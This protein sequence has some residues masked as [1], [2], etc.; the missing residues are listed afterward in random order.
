VQRIPA[1][2]HL[3]RHAHSASYVTLVLEGFYEQVGYAGRW[4]AQAGDVLIQ[5][6]LDC[7]ADTMHSRGLV[8][9]R[10]PWRHEAGPGGVWRG[11]D[12]DEIRRAGAVDP[13]AGRALVAAR[14]AGRPP[15]AAVEEHWVDPLAARL[16]ADPRQSIAGWAEGVGRSREAA[17]RAFQA[18]FGV[19]PARLRLELRTRA[20][21]LRIVG[22]REALAAIAQELGFADQAHMTRAVRWLTQATPGQWR[23]RCSNAGSGPKT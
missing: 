9:M 6:T 3:P 1:G 23:A 19:A 15:L 22:T 14:V 8:L 12:V 5:P 2:Q 18:R 4:R 17:A 7:H 21:W 20:A 13:A 10:L 16:A 11:L